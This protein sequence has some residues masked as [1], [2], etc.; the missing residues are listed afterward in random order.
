MNWRK[1]RQLLYITSG[2]A[3]FL[4]ILFYG[5]YSYV[6]TP[7]T[8]FD[9]TQDDGELG[10]DCGGPC[11][12]LCAFQTRDPVVSWARA[13]PVATSTYT[14]AAYIT[15]PQASLGGVAY[16]VGYVFRFY[17]ADNHLII[18]QPGTV[19]LPAVETIPVVAPN[20]NTGS[21]V[22]GHTQFSFTTAP[23]TW[24]KLREADRPTFT[25]K[26]I[27]Y[28]QDGT[29]LSATVVNE[30]NVPVNGLT[31]AGVL[32]DA[33]NNATAA[34]RS[35]IQSI[36]AEGQDEVVFTW[37]NP[38]QGVVRAEVTP[39]PSLPPNPQP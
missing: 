11:A 30:T 8:C 26:D 19:D 38:S 15:N 9:R 36:D 37:P 20:V 21:E 34:S 35:V 29:R 18:E 6:A 5:A 27:I 16:Q 23:I 39:L 10:V 22:V 3:V 33:D 2:L 25:V 14:A 7:G 17:T 13:L 12:R 4:G 31:V 24:T 1:R 32:F 28:A